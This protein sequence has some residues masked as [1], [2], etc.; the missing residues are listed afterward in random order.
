MSFET[1]V[2][3]FSYAIGLSLASNLLQSGI[4][5]VEL[6]A[7][8]EAISDVM[9]GKQPQISPQ[10]ANQVIETYFND[11][12]TNEGAKNASEGETFLAKNKLE[13]GVVELASGLQYKILTEGTGS[14]PQANDKV[15]CHYH[16]TLIDGTV[17][18]SSVQR[19]TPAEFPVNGVIKGWVE[20]LQLM[21]VGSKWR[22]FI[23]SHLAYG[24]QG[25][26]G[27]IGPKATLIFDV[28]LIDIV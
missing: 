22:L 24:D 7:L 10:E 17:F 1:Q 16:G 19:G 14:K 15:K 5:K 6:E 28:E 8:F 27:S 11:R 20:A 25:A 9:A 18:D 4:N 12:Q 21:P 23:P 13:D 26:G 3:K 2:E